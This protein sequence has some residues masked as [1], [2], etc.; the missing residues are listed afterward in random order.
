MI[1]P[2][3]REW[4]AMYTEEFYPEDR[5]GGAIDR[6]DA[7]LDY[8]RDVYNDDTGIILGDIAGANVT[9]A[10]S[11]LK[12]FADIEG[13]MG[14]M[15]SVLGLTA[16]DKL[17]ALP[18]EKEDPRHW[19][20][21]HLLKQAF[22]LFGANENLTALSSETAL[23]NR[24]KN[25]AASGLLTLDRKY[26]Y[27]KIYGFRNF[28]M[29]H[30]SEDN[31][32]SGFSKKETEAVISSM[33]MVQLDLC[34]TYDD[35]LKEVYA[36]RKEQDLK[37]SYDASRYVQEIEKE[38]RAFCDAGFDYL[39]TF[40]D[41]S[42]EGEEK[43]NIDGFV[44][45]QGSA[46]TM[47]LGEAGSGKTTALRRLEYLFAKKSIRE[48]GQKW[49]PILIELKSLQPGR[50]P[51]LYEIESRLKY[52]EEV[53]RQILKDGSVI[54]LLDGWN[55][56]SS[57]EV[58]N[59]LRDELQQLID[60]CGIHVF[61]TDRSDKNVQLNTLQGIT[62]CYL[63]E[64]SYDDKRTYFAGNCRDEEILSLISAEI[65]REESGEASVTPV[66]NLKTPLMLY[67]F[68]KVVE[69]DRAIPGNSVAKYIELLFHREE[70]E[71]KD[72]DD[73]QS[74]EAMRYILSALAMLYEEGD[75]FT[76]DALITVGRVKRL[77]GFNQPDS[78]QFLELSCKMGLLENADDIYR[79]KTNE[80]QDYFQNYAMMHGIDDAL[81]EI[82]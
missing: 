71:Q 62:R 37:S 55:E 67:Y 65:D 41:I 35:R 13:F 16:P 81:S 70:T 33:L 51:I 38:Y 22:C 1:S 19:T 60:D 48:H 31:S 44:N 76:S 29:A 27:L 68:L 3:T 82:G 36:R 43:K 4:I 15:G 14:R 47:F 77:F 26:H 10:R 12:S 50:S 73:P 78:M 64:L 59:L 21:V 8:L 17:T 28:V 45:G 58:I 56:I 25:N 2:E 72:A 11:Y 69:A 9:K 63:H 7:Y 74:F 20:M 42:S 5:I 40:W 6:L 34:D 61:I 80:F 49:I 66:F 18:H 53:A 24:Y 79:F 75:F 57:K 54:L 46:V 52:S 23:E 39:D 30:F 32:L